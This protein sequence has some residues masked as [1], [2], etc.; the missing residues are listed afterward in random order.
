MRRA[1]EYIHEHLAEPLR[2]GKVA[3]VAGFA[4]GYF[5]KLLGRAHGSSFENYTRRIRLERA[6][7]MLS[8]TS[9]SVERVARLCGFGSRNYLHEA[10][11]AAFATTPLG[12]RIRVR[13]D[14]AEQLLRVTAE[15]VERVAEVSGFESP[16]QLESAF[17]TAL[18][19]TPLEYRRRHQPRGRRRMDRRTKPKS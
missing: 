11:R 7:Q 13:L 16:E 19:V 15:S 6:K 17:K 3:S 4:P 8:D 10:F 2:L 9:L 18:G 12:Y 1:T 14:R 5:S